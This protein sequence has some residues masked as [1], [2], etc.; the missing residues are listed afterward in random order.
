MLGMYN[1]FLQMVA[2]VILS[3]TSLVAGADNQSDK[4]DSPRTS[5]A[6]VITCKKMIDDGLYKSLKRRTEEAL[7]QGAEYLIYEIST[8]GGLVQSGDDISK[9]LF[10]TGQK[11]KTIAY[12]K[13][14]AISAGAMIAVSCRDIVMRENTKIGDC[15]PI[16]MGGKLEGVEREKAESFVRAIFDTAAK[17]NHY[18]RALLRAMVTMQIEVYRVK[19]LQTQEFEYFE[20][21]DVPSDANSYDLENKNVVVGDDEL[22]TVDAQSALDYGI[23]RAVVKNR[24]ELMAFLSQRDHVTFPDAPVIL[25]PNWS[26]Q[27]VRAIN[28][29][30]VMGILVM[31]AMLGLYMEFSTPG[32]G[33]P[34]LAAVICFVIL[35]GSKYLIGLANWVEVAVF[36]LGILL[37]FVEI[38]LIPGFGLAGITGI[39]CILLGLFGMLIR[40]APDEWPWPRDPVSW[41]TLRQGLLGLTI[42][43]A[44]FLGLACIF[45]RYFP[46]WR[47][48]S[49]LILTPN[50]ANANQTLPVS[51]SRPTIQQTRAVQIGDI[52]ETKTPLHPSGRVQFDDKLVDCVARGEFIE[53]SHRVEVT[54]IH[55]NRVVVRPLE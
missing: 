49:G 45:A 18:P 27:M 51:Q 24:E 55:G 34:G 44:G 3:L 23:A 19:N 39:V 13:T 37:L 29:P 40:N 53:K 47:L 5:K 52:G 4:V 38:F 25:V 6:A 2:I 26:E 33:L 48:F 8:Y 16:T 10:E 32:V 7:G 54:A 31:I 11:A 30:T 50:P 17:A 22:L 36:V 42:G 14:E 9:L 20:T 21:S 46:R 15:A 35:I 1:S 43:M 12:V 41:M 28:H